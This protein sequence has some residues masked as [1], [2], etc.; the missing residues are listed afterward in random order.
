VHAV[1]P[2]ETRARAGIRLV[3]SRVA[4]LGHTREGHEKNVGDRAV[5]GDLIH[6][7]G[8]LY[9]CLPR[10][11]RFDLSL[12][13]DSFMNGERSLLDD[14]DCSPRMGVPAGGA[15][16]LDRELNH[17]NVRPELKRDGPIGDVV[18]TRQ[19]DLRQP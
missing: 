10:A 14:D 16:W 18:S 9:E 4:A 15:T 12:A 17:D 19:E 11:I 1:N 3:N 13:A 6:F 5:I 8:P 7:A 2:S